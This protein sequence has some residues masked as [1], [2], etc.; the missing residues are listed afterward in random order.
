MNALKKLHPDPFSSDNHEEQTKK[1]APTYI[2]QFLQGTN[3]LERFDICVTDIV[4][5]I[6]A[7][8]TVNI[9]N[10]NSWN[11]YSELNPAAREAL[12]EFGFKA[13]SPGNQA[14]LYSPKHFFA[15][16]Q[17]RFARGRLLPGK[18]CVIFNSRKGAETHEGIRQNYQHFRTQMPLS[19]MSDEFFVAE[20]KI[21]NLWVIYQFDR[22]HLN[23]WLV[24]GTVKQSGTRMFCDDHK[25]ICSKSLIETPEVDK[26]DLPPLPP[27]ADITVPFGKKAGAS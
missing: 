24:E 8:K 26:K 21:L 15:S 20:E 18:G 12:L 13:Y 3:I 19:F 10:A 9:R 22:E 11:A 25:L 7:G 6:L 2:D 5:E 1:T 17:L 16:V 14:R 23:A 27:P 4:K